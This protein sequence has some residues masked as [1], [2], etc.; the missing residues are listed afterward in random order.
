MF[1]SSASNLVANDTNGAIDVFVHD[2]QTGITT[3]ASVS[4]AGTTG[5]AG[6]SQYPTVSDDGRYLVFHSGA[7]DLVPGDTNSVTDVF[8]RDRQTGTTT[9][10]SVR[11]DGSQTFAPSSF[12]WISGD[13]SHVAFK[14]SDSLVPSDPFGTTDLW[15]KDLGSSALAIVTVTTLGSPAVDAG[16]VVGLSADGRY[17]LVYSSASDLVASDINPGFDFFVR[18][19]VLATTELVT[20][21][22]NGAQ[23]VGTHWWASIS[24]DGRK[25][26]FASSTNNI[27]TGDTNNL[28]DAF[29]RDR[30]LGTVARVSLSTAGAQG[31]DDVRHAAIS[32]DGRY[33]AFPTS[34]TN[35]VSGDTNGW[36]DVFLRDT[37]A[38]GCGTGGVAST[39]GGTFQTGNAAFGFQVT[40]ADPGALLLLDFGFATP[41]LECGTCV[42]T[43]P[44]VLVTATNVSGTGQFGFSVPND[45]SY[46]GPTFEFQW[47]SFFTAVS[48]CP[49]LGS[50]SATGRVRFSAV[51]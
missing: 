20:L 16:D 19:T 4:P 47:L 33:V 29:V 37:E 12:A 6:H 24:A 36:S 7:Q 40:G 1:E 17:V 43:A 30:W 45:P 26:A 46:I 35:L 42:I 21:R 32:G 44:V 23:A 10:I 39:Y 8:H 28:A 31:D 25:V 3:C 41:G 2:R 13:G 5:A 50:M 48:P 38:A 11:S 14:S 22:S 51:Q 18:D 15:I 9:R 49:L 34:A 27:V